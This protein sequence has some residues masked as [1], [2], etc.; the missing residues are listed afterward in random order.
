MQFVVDR[1]GRL[2]DQTD[3]RVKRAGERKRSRK[4]TIPTET[5]SDLLPNTGAAQRRLWARVYCI[6]RTTVYTDRRQRRRRRWPRDLLPLRTNIIIV[7]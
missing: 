5:Y 2:H 6:C 3:S 1:R 7:L 4:K